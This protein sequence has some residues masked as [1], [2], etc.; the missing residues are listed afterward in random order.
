M[1]KGAL[2]AI[3][4]QIK[5]AYIYDG[6]GGP[7]FRGSVLVHHDKIEAVGCFESSYPAFDAEGMMLCPGF[8]DIHRHADVKPLTGW[9]GSTELKQ[10]I[11]STVVG[12]CGISLTPASRRFQK[13]QY[14]FA[15]A[16][17]GNIP[18][19]A[20]LS[21]GGY[22]KNLENRPLPLNFSAMIGTGSVKISLNGFESSA[23]T[24]TQLDEAERLIEEALALGAPG[25]SMGIMYTPECFTSFAEYVRML[26]PLGIYGRVLTAHIRGEGDSLAQSVGE[27]VSIAEA[28]GCPLEISHF[29][30]C[31]M[32]NWNK[33]IYK[34]IE[35]I[36]RARNRGMDVTCDFYPYCGGST[37]LTTML[38]PV[39]CGEGIDAAYRELGNS[40]GLEKFRRAVR[41][42]Y[43]GWDNYAVSL[44]WDRIIISSVALEENKKYLGLSILSAAEK[45]GYEDPEALAAHLMHTEGGGCGIIN[46]SMDQSDVDAI[47]EL[48]YSLLISDALYA[49]TDTPHPRLLGAF[50]KFLREYVFERKI[51]TPEEGI[52]KMTSAP[53]KRMGFS[54]RG[55][56]KPGYYADLLVFDKD[57]FTDNAD[58]SGRSEKA[59]G[60][61]L[62]LINGCAAIED[63]E[64]TGCRAGRLLTL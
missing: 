19:N 34:A 26:K 30:S 58:F 6:T 37:M 22:I 39:L 7:P 25:I 18:A 15:A 64:L 1:W 20:P 11:T 55:M 41:S 21:Y 53:A 52:R 48:P 40:S 5:N 36:E 62:S 32:K 51:V 59:C 49:E 2:I 61:A 10:G 54:G 4:L 28:V 46:M 24:D 60:L 31:G 63:D 35:V 8:I 38:P 50:P 47:A 23:L 27:A 43:D 14:G 42:V 44:G 9:D 29:K 3:D 56:I 33:E 45:Y 17:L 13:E 57:K 12:N 16:V